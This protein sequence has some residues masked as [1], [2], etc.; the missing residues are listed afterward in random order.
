MDSASDE[1]QWAESLIWLCPGAPSPCGAQVALRRSPTRSVRSGAFILAHC[2]KCRLQ[3]V[4]LEQVPHLGDEI[5]AYFKTQLRQR[6][7][8]A[9]QQRGEDRRCRSA[10]TIVPEP[11]KLQSLNC[12]SYVDNRPLNF[13]DPTGN[14][15]E[16]EIMKTFHVKTREEVLAI[17]GK[18]GLLEGRRGWLGTLRQAENEGGQH[19]RRAN[20]SINMDRGLGHGGWSPWSEPSWPCSSHFVNF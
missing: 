8:D 12:Y 17:F 3:C 13:T 14:F 1:K 16:N 7:R 9:Q 20:N 19:L 15:F 10:D 2:C 18:S 11:G 5:K 4:P 6:Q